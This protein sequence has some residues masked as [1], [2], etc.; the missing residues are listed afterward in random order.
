MGMFERWPLFLTMHVKTFQFMLRY[1]T[2]QQKNHPK[3]I[4]QWTT[5]STVFKVGLQAPRSPTLWRCVQVNEN[6]MPV[7]HLHYWWEGFCLRRGSIPYVYCTVGKST[8][9]FSIMGQLT[10]GGGK[11]RERGR[12]G[13]ALS[14]NWCGGLK[15]KIWLDE[16][17][18][19]KCVK[20]SDFREV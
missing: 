15:K 1:S 12:E 7:I 14:G 13:G 10:L 18:D 2:L 4:N 3:Q 17:L 16:W 5:S 9:G 8:F 19:V 11:E 20:T 6:I